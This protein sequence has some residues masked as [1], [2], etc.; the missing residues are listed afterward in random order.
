MNSQ[1]QIIIGSLAL[2]AIAG[3][4]LPLGSFLAEQWNRRSARYA[5]ASSAV[6]LV[7][8]M[9]G[10]LTGSSVPELS[11]T[12]L[13]VLST[14]IFVTGASLCGIWTGIAKREYAAAAIGMV[15]LL[16]SGA[17]MGILVVQGAQ[18]EIEAE[19]AEAC[20]RSGVL[21]AVCE[22]FASVFDNT[23]AADIIFSPIQGN[24]AAAREALMRGPHTEE[25]CLLDLNGETGQT[26]RETL[27]EILEKA[28]QPE[29]IE[30]SGIRQKW[31]EAVAEGTKENTP[32]IEFRPEAVDCRLEK[33]GEFMVCRVAKDTP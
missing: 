19:V 18:D 20:E 8:G 9:L 6:L 2:M 17:T 14:A 33:G 27:L 10:I 28:S 11:L 15:L 25:D 4:L 13:L 30:A 23:A 3:L 22:R 26:S 21:P 29:E 12:V 5:Y 1:I 24:P 31:C 7:L 16:A 32:D